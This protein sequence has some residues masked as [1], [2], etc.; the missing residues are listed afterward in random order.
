[1]SDPR[2]PQLYEDV[3]NLAMKLREVAE[4]HVLETPPGDRLDFLLIISSPSGITG[5]HT[6]KLDDGEPDADAAVAALVRIARQWIA[7]GGGV[8]LSDDRSALQIIRERFL[9]W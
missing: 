5:L 3:D 6:F 8:D 2:L 4:A 1:M 7:E 9:R